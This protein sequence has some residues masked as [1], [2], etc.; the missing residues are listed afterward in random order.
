M[1]MKTITVALLL[2]SFAYAD[3]IE[4]I[5]NKLNRTV[6]DCPER[7][8]PGLNWSTKPIILVDKAEDRAVL[9]NA[10]SFENLPASVAQNMQSTFEFG[11]W[12]SQ[13]ALYVDVS[14]ADSEFDFFELTV[15]EAFHYFNQTDLRYDTDGRRGIV[16]IN[17]E[18]R[19]QRES[20]ANELSNF[21]LKSDVSALN[22]AKAWHL[23]HR[24][25]DESLGL[26]VVEGSAKYV[27][28]VATALAQVGCSAPEVTLVNAAAEIAAEIGTGFDQGGQSYKVGAL[29]LLVARKNNVEVISHLNGTNGLLDLVLK[30]VL[31]SPQVSAE[32]ALR[33]AALEQISFT[34]EWSME[35]IQPIRQALSAGSAFVFV[36]GS[37]MLGSFSSE[38]MYTANDGDYLVNAEVNTLEGNFKGHAKEVE[39]CGEMGFLILTNALPGGTPSTYEN[40]PITCY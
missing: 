3:S 21:L 35:A 15:H 2:S 8:W 18:P 39:A 24:S 36:K 30:D 31:E 40:S 38:G 11:V 22:N 16:P 23:L 34:N 20:L 33:A 4:D 25:S 14:E 13:P 32:P 1:V 5:R 17:P 10:G 26:D 6:Y 29:A 27:E 12:Q 7:I 9:I 19:I 37:S 28:V